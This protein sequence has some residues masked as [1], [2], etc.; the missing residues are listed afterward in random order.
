MLKLKTQL[1]FTCSNSTIGTLCTPVTSVSIIDF[2]Q[3]S[4]TWE[5]ACIKL[6]N[7]WPKSE[8]TYYLGSSFALTN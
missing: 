4:V 2:E 7:H 3:L 1:S 6:H 8:M 5:A